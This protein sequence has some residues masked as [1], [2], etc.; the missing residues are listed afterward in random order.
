MSWACN[1]RG[2]RGMNMRFGYEN[3]YKRYHQEDLDI[4]WRIILTLI[5]EKLDEV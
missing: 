4:D 3:T 5:L 2:R 1:T